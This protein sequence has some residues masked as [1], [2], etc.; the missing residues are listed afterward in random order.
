MGATERLR[1]LRAIAMARLWVD[2]LIAGAVPD[3]AALATREGKSE[4]SVR[5]TLLLAFLD[6][7]LVKAATQGRLPRGHGVAPRRSAVALRGSMA[8]VGP[9][10]AR[11]NFQA[12]LPAP[13]GQRLART[14]QY[15]RARAR[16]ANSNR[17]PAL[18]NR[19]LASLDG[20]SSENEIR[21]RETGAIFAPV[22]PRNSLLETGLPQAAPRKPRHCGR[23]RGAAETS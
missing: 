12:Y 6:P 23:P 15:Q 13:R 18:S 17:S 11:L 8:G 16:G 21:R 19:S 10:P 4:R 7:A 14:R 9:R 5:M 22:P 2:E 3:L 20:G 1:L